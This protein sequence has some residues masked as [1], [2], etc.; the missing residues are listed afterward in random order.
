MPLLSHI[1]G[2][3]LTAGKDSWNIKKTQPSDGVANNRSQSAATNNNK[4]RPT[5]R[6]MRGIMRS[7]GGTNGVKLRTGGLTWVF[8]L[9]PVPSFLFPLTPFF[10]FDALCWYAE[11]Q[12]PLSESRADFL[13]PFPLICVPH[14]HEYEHTMALVGKGICGGMDVDHACINTFSAILVSTLTCND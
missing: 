2:K 4:P 10:L 1:S 9:P 11:W 14:S 7:C 3:G 8:P 12:I 13:S 6:D 5:K